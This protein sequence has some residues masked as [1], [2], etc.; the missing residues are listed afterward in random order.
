MAV[1]IIAHRGASADAPENTLA[2]FDLAIAHGAKMIEC[3]VHQSRDGHPVIIHD[4]TLRRTAG[5][6]RLVRSLT[7][8]ELRRC[9]VGRW[10]HARYAGERIPTLDEVLAHLKGRVRLNL[11]IKRGSP[12]YPQIEARVVEAVTASGAVETLLI[13]SFE[14]SV[15]TRVRAL[16]RQIRLGV[17]MTQ[18]GPR[19]IRRAVRLRAETVYVPARTITPRFIAKAHAAGLL[20]YPYTVDREPEMRRLILMGVDGLFTNHP[21]RLA[22]LQAREGLRPA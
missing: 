6:R 20:V 22:H 4:F 16:S 2:A 15:L 12:Y 18:A 7:L 8:E 19:A 5:L 1:L 17:L 21:A 9:D 14:S 3:D 13:S 11:E 10:F